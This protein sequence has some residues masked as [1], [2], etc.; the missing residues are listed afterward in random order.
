MNSSQ[1]KPAWMLGLLVWVA[2]IAGG[3]AWLL[4]YSFSPGA[5]AGAP[6]A[7]PASLDSSRQPARPHLFLALHPRCPCS[8]ATLTELGKILSRSRDA[9]E[10]TVLLYQPA[11]ESDN[12]TSGVLLDE[13]RRLGCIIRHDADGRL[14]AG[15]GCSTS[16]SVVLYD[17]QGR[18]RY[19]GGITMARGHEG[20]NAGERGVIEILQGLRASQVSMP[21]FGCPLQ[22]SG[23]KARQL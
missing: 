18:L 13:C 8:R 22:T 12:W 4:Q 3:Q 7:I 17:T 5:I 15:L 10:V 16:G 14:A 1:F 9:T 6:Q 19:H 23:V 21:V 2:C 20:D 11:N